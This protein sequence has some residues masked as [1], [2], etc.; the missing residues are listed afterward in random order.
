MS[1]TRG[2]LASPAPFFE[3]I[4]YHDHLA[5]GWDQRLVHV[6][7]AGERA[8]DVAKVN[9]ALRQENR[10]AA[11]GAHGGRGGAAVGAGRAAAQ[12]LRGVYVSESES[13][14]AASG[15]RLT[16]R[17]RQSPTADRR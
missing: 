15:R 14:V 1:S 12:G 11:A 17:N 8:L 3:A 5:A 6:Q 2:R 4:A 9:P 13:C 16:I 7:G 10:L